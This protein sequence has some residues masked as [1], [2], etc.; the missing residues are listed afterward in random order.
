MSI[1][2]P[3]QCG[4]L[5]LGW[6]RWPRLLGLALHASPSCDRSAAR[7]SCVRTVAIFGFGKKPA[8]P[9]DSSRAK[10]Q[11]AKDLEKVDQLI[12]VFEKVRGGA[13]LAR[14]QHAA[15]DALHRL[16]VEQAAEQESTGQSAAAAAAAAASSSS[17]S[18]RADSAAQA[19]SSGSGPSTAGEAIRRGLEVYQQG[20]YKVRRPCCSRRY[21]SLSTERT[22]IFTCSGGDRALLPVPRAARERRDA[23]GRVYQGVLVPLGGKMLTRLTDRVVGIRDTL[24]PAC[25]R[26]RSRLP[27]TTWPAATPAW[28]RRTPP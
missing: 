16:Q 26:A 24:A 23:D 19:T 1:P 18:V 20:N 15:P 12:G 14:P 10:Q 8:T 4:Q 27:S 17:S 22:A 7:P 11:S 28:A 21:P 3:G 6:R 2:P 9:E 5:L 25:R 13:S